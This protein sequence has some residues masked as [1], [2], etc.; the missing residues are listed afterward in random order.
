MMK[1]LIHKTIEKAVEI[2]DSMREKEKIARLKKADK[3]KENFMKELHERMDCEEKEEEK[4]YEDMEI[5]ENVK[6]LRLKKSKYHNE[7]LIWMLDSRMDCE[8]IL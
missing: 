7:F 1:E 4:K 8:H 3:L 5:E 2:E 6:Y